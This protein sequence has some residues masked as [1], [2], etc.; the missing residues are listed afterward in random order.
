MNWCRTELPST[1][2]NSTIHLRT[3]Q[4]S[5]TYIPKLEFQSFFIFRPW[6]QTSGGFLEANLD[7][8]CFIHHDHL[9]KILPWGLPDTQCHD[10]NSFPS[11]FQST[12]WDAP[13]PGCCCVLVYCWF[14]S[15]EKI[16]KELLHFEWSPPWHV[17]WGLS[18][19]GCYHCFLLFAVL[20]LVS[21]RWESLK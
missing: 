11:H 6:H 8:Q 14:P 10:G 12:C 2:I 3:F 16:S 1:F 20:L 13:E 9:T 4:W 21:F 15:F 17:G 7:L 19:E 5:A 18:G